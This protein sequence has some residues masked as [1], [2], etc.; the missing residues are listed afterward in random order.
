[1]TAAFPSEEG[2]EEDM[3]EEEREE[4]EKIEELSCSIALLTL[5]FFPE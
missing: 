2:E 5:S 1:M 3:E 4:D